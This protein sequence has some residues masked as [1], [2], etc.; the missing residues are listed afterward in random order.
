MKISLALGPRQKLSRQ[1]AWGCFTTNLAVPGFGSLMAGRISGYF[2]AALAFG[3]L[4]L[5][6]IFG[7]RFFTWYVTNWSRLQ[8][9]DG[10]PF[11]A[12]GE[13]WEAAKW[14]LLGMLVFGAGWLWGLATGW[15]IVHA[16]K[17][18]ETSNPPPKL[19]PQG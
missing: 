17:K 3:G 12:L 13:M 19:G 11:G 9:Q 2:Q 4:A 6:L 18:E 10:D 1:T 8:S 15:S 14:P 7:A 16:A 5:T